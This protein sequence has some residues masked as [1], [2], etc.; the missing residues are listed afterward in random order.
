MLNNLCIHV[1]VFALAIN[2][3]L[4]YNYKAMRFKSV[5]LASTIIARM[6]IHTLKCGIRTIK[7]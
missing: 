3:L 6:K 5:A 7:R 4:A 2:S 1:C